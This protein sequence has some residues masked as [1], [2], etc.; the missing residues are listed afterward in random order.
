MLAGNTPSLGTTGP[1]QARRCARCKASALED[2]E[3]CQRHRDKQLAYQAKSMAK[4][5]KTRRK[6]G[7]CFGCGKAKARSLCP[8]CRI[9]WDRTGEMRSAG[10]VKRSVKLPEITAD[11]KAREGQARRGR[12]TTESLD[13]QDLG[14][15]FRL[16]TRARDELKYL[17]SDE[18]KVLPV[19]QRKDAERAALSRVRLASGFLDDVLDRNG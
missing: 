5:R 1:P 7:L 19:L 2:G 3:L 9:K 12:Q 16:V 17:R 11:G 18:A 13:D 14:D 8:R 4:L 10:V 6:A 15:A